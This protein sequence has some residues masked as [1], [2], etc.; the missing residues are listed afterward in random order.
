M[1]DRSSY[2]VVLMF[3]LLILQGLFNLLAEQ[4][5]YQISSPLL[6]TRF[7]RLGLGSKTLNFIYCVAFPGSA[8]HYLRSWRCRSVI[9]PV[10][11][12]IKTSRFTAFGARLPQWHARPSLNVIFVAAQILIKLL[13]QA[14]GL[15]RALAAAVCALLTPL[16]LRVSNV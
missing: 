5:E 14:A 1:A 4:T 10:I 11:S 7:A 2:E 13:R 9:K 16:H 3:T 8:Y 6:F 12:D 15:L